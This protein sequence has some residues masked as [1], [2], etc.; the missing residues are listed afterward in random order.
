MHDN[1]E[2]ESHFLACEHEHRDKGSSLNTDKYD[3]FHMLSALQYQTLDV[4]LR[5]IS[6]EHSDGNFTK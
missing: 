4:T 2:N 6:T 1:N 3:R 5:A